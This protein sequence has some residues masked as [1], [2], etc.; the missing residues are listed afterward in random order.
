MANKL[1]NLIIVNVGVLKWMY[2]YRRW[3]TDGRLVIRGKI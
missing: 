1:I 3:Y 2:L